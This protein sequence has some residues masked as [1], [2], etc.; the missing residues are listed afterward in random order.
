MGECGDLE[1]E[2]KEIVE[3][4]RLGTP[5][6]MMAGETA[7]GGEGSDEEGKE[8][9]EDIV[10]PNDPLYGLDARMAQLDLDDDSKAV[11]RTKLVEASNKIKEGLEKRQVD[12]DTKMAAMPAGKKR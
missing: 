1:S 2:C 10:D 8:E 7:V 6:E 12:L 5:E 11:L 9:E 4:G 3:E